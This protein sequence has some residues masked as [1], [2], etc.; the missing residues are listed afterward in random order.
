M[1]GKRVAV[2]VN[3]NTLEHY[4]GEVTD[5]VDEN[6]LLIRNDQGEETQVSIFDVRNPTQEL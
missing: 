2:V 4:Y 6:T 3:Y 5:A 1:I